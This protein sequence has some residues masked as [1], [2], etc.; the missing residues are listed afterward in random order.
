MLILQIPQ[1]LYNGGKGKLCHISEVIAQRHEERT[2]S[3]Q[4]KVAADKKGKNRKG[5]LTVVVENQA[6][7]T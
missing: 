4:F 5:S 7:S 6:S 1:F 3:K 2:G